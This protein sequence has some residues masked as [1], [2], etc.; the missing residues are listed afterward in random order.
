MRQIRERMQ[1][2]NNH[3][4]KMVGRSGKA[5]FGIIAIGL[6]FISRDYPKLAGGLALVI[7][8]IGLI[9]YGGVTRFLK[10]MGMA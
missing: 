5:G 4:E 7:G 10:A 3:A 6:A 2:I 8:G 1:E 9:T